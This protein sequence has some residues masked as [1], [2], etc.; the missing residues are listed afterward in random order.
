MHSYGTD[1]TD[2]VRMPL[3]L[4]AVAVGI[5]FLIYAL[6]KS[7]EL[8]IPWWIDIPGPVGIGMILLR[9]YD[10]VAWRWRFGPISLSRIPYLGG[11]WEG[12]M[13]SNYDEDP[14]PHMG[15]LII[16]QRWS[17]IL[18]RF[19]PDGESSLSHSIM[20]VVN[21]SESEG[22]RSLAYEYF[23]EP[24]ALSTGSMAAHRGV[25]RMSLESND[26]L[27]GDYYNGRGRSTGGQMKF[28]RVENYSHESANS[29]RSLDDI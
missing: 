14:G 8:N 5:S 1:A 4:G 28:R 3:M 6:L 26:I 9:V 23:N 13:S 10:R 17:K 15:R 20:A 22:R 16:T 19:E 7:A 27:V 24:R 2:R 12:S 18:I 29:D 21:T 25:A 11:I